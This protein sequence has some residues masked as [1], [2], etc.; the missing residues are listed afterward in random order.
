[1][2]DAELCVERRG[3]VHLLTIE[4]ESAGNA[5]SREVLDALAE[6]VGNVERDATAR[7][8]VVASAGE[9]FFCTGGDV[10]RYRALRSREDLDE[11]FGQARELMD[12]I[13]GLPVPVIAAIEGLTLGGGSELALAC[14]VR[15]GSERSR[16]GF[17][18]VRLGLMPGWHGTERL[19]R[20]CGYARAMDLLLSGE[21]L[22]AEAAHRAGLSTR[23]VD[24]GKALDAALDLAR[25]IETTAPLSHP[26]IKRALQAAWAESRPRARAIAEEAFER[27][28]LSEDHREAEAAFAEKREP[29]FRG[30]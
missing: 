26:A 21:T 20:V 17:P 16:I 3:A 6:A 29:V 2:Q 12:R 10:K 30:R 9:R 5:L 8:V 7:A 18:Y 24:A 14:D 13:E 25:S 23:V 11:T 19:L 4:R 15:V 22:D 27:L 1:M 28:W